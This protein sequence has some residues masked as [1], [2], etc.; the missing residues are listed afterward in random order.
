VPAAWATGTAGRNGLVDD[1]TDGARAAA[2]LGAAAETAINLPGRA[3]RIAATERRA[4]IVIAQHIART[5]DHGE[6]GV[7]ER[8]S[9]LCNYRYKRPP[10]QAKTKRRVFSYSNVRRHG[11]AGVGGAL[12]FLQ[13]AA[14]R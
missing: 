10:R 5:D 11:A 1:A 7:P 6:L 3:R 13:A 9:S 4:D 12:A 8:F 2:A 14:T